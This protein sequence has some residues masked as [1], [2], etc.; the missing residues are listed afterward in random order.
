M[1]MAKTIQ[2]EET[3]EVRRP[4]YDVGEFSLVRARFVNVR[5]GLAGPAYNTLI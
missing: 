1:S 3:V 5:F 4:L 2:P